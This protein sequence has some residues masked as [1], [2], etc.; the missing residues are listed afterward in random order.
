MASKRLIGQTRYEDGEMVV[1]RTTLPP[2]PETWTVEPGDPMGRLSYAE[3]WG[4]A[5]HGVNWAQRK[6]VRLLVPLNGEA[7]RMAFRAFTPEGGRELRIEVNG[8]KVQWIGMAAG[9]MEY[10]VD[11]PADLVQPGLNEVWLRFD[12]LTPASQV[13]LSPRAIGQTGVES[14]V[15]LAVY[16]AGQEVGNLGHIYVDGRDA[17][18]NERGYNVVVLDPQSGEV[19]QAAAFDTH[20]DEG[21]SRALAAFLGG[22][23]EGHLVAVAAA[24]EASRLL[25]Q[26]AVDA[27]RGI[28]ATGDLRGRFRWGHAI[29]GVQGAAPGTALEVMDWMRPVTLVVGEGA[30]EPDL[31]AALTTLTFTATDSP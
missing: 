4:V 21:A 20:L 25:G 27:L 2:W 3:G 5:A 7:Q 29:V 10:E 30:T 13:R 22:V 26:E 23:P 18:P 16:S 24:D 8:R 11:L 15:N 1:Y 31:A 12:R 14:P 6:A 9:W 17:A 28:G 19:V